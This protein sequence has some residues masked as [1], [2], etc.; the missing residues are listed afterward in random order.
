MG[1]FIK[2]MNIFFMNVAELYN[3]KKGNSY[4]TLLLFFIFDNHNSFEIDASEIIFYI[5]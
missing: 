3:I 4:S 2:I 1:K 5:L